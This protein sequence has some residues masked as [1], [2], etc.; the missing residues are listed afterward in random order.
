MSP[1]GKEVEEFLSD[2][3]AGQGLGCGRHRCAKTSV[4]IC[5]FLF[6]HSLPVREGCRLATAPEPPF[7]GGFFIAVFT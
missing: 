2:L 1:F 4:W 6:S 3:A 5:M 7:G